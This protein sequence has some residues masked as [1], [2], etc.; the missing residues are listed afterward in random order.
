MA[1]VL[2]M[3]VQSLISQNLVKKKN[4]CQQENDLKKKFTKNEKVIKKILVD[5][6]L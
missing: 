3:E 6:Q 5:L 4:N 2:S 1:L